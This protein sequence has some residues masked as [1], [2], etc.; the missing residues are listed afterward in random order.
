MQAAPVDPGG[1]ENLVRRFA[2]L[3]P[4]PPRVVL[5]TLGDESVALG[6]ARLTLQAVEE[7]LFDVAVS[8][9]V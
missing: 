9:A 1:G 4:V 6:A 5:S 2:G 7:R 8:E 3:V